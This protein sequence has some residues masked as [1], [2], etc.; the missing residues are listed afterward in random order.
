M[1]RTLFA[2]ILVAVVPAACSRQ[3]DRPPAS[4]AE[5][6]RVTAAK[7]PHEIATYIYANY[8]CKNCHTIAS[9]GKFG[10]TALGE[11]LKGKSEGC[12]AMLTSMHRILA[13]PEANRTPEHREKLAHFNEYGCSSCHQISL[14]TVSLTEVGARLKELHMACTE[15]Q[16]VLN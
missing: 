13:L 15:V 6:Q 7:S 14:G 10:Y 4:L 9:G 2:A 8:G 11:Q 16:K 5:L 3:P 12:V 1:K